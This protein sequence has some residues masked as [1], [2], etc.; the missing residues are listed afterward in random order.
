MKEDKKEGQ[1]RW[2]EQTT[3]I[4]YTYTFKKPGAADLT[5]TVF[6]K[7][8]VVDDEEVQAFILEDVSHLEKKKQAAADLEQKDLKYREQEARNEE[9]QLQAYET[10]KSCFTTDSIW[11]MDEK[12]GKLQELK[13]EFLFDVQVKFVKITGVSKKKQAVGDIHGKLCDQFTKTINLQFC[14]ANKQ[15]VYDATIV[16]IQCNERSWSFKSFVVG[17]NKTAR[18]RTRITRQRIGI[19]KGHTETRR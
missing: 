19:C 17:K 3:E 9:M 12:Q 1:D 16:G 5:K 2:G 18:Y 13:S 15:P 4:K 10:L 6:V 14:N 8:N 7:S 11:E